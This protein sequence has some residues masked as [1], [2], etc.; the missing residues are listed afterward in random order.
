VTP[1]V[2]DDDDFWWCA[3]ETG[4]LHTLP[5][6]ELR[7]YLTDRTIPAHALVWQE[8]WGTWVPAARVPEL[9]SVLSGAEFDLGPL[10][11][12]DREGSTPP[13]PPLDWYAKRRAVTKKHKV[14]DLDKSALAPARLP[15]DVTPIMPTPL[16]DQL[17]AASTEVE[18]PTTR[19]P[20]ITLP[21]EAFPEREAFLAHVRARRKKTN[22]LGPP[23]LPKRRR[24]R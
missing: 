1:S 9:R 15:A 21:E 4:E 23:P 6:T 8:G 16:F 7:E 24:R 10:P 20:E 19:A 17:T 5:T 22:T 14:I 11:A 13:P 18:R 2:T 3:D 12:R